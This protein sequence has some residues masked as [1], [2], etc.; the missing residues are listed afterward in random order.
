MTAAAEAIPPLQQETPVTTAPT[1]TTIPALF[2]LT[3]RTALISGASGHLGSAF[4]AA[5]AEAGATVICSSIDRGRAEA[6]AAKLPAAPGV[7][8]HGV[9][10]DQMDEDAAAAGFEEAVGCTGQIDILVNNGHEASKSDLTDVGAAEFTRQLSNATGWFL[11]SR[12]LRDHVA[13]RQGS[14]SIIL[15]G[16]MYGV[17]GS[18]PDAYEDV[19]P[20]SPVAYHCLKGG[21]IHMTRHLAVYWAPDNIRVNCLSPGPFPSAH[22]PAEMVP[23]LCAKS[24][25]G[26]MGAPHELKGALIYLASDASSYVTGQNLVIDGGW[27]AW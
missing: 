13:A 12:M 16:S 22:A 9:L 18:Y 17:V 1:P 19:C 10:L 7:T 6:A 20:A 8:H 23:R 25:M 24:P 4:A 2:D 15:I 14:G 3:G 27:T 21:I 5:L 26:R 11:L